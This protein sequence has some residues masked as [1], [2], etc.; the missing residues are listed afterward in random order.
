MRSYRAGLFSLSVAAL[1]MAGSSAEAQGKG[2]GKAKAKAGTAVKA[3]A[4]IDSRAGARLPDGTTV[5]DV[6]RARR[7]QRDRGNVILRDRRD[8]D[9]GIW[10]DG[11]RDGRRD[12]ASRVYGNGTK[13][14]PGLAKKP[15]QMP[16]GQYKKYYTT[17]QGA[18]VLSDILRGRGYPVQ[19]ISPYGDGQAVFYRRP[20][21]TIAR[22]VVSQRSDRLGFSN[23]PSAVLA[24][25]M[26]RLY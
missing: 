19:R 17:K 11:R 13:V 15:G 21:G 2:Q 26:A 22:A 1:L 6:I 23:I 5:D 25:V 10:R 3:N 9:D 18:G 7:D 16:P 14:P 12:G 24:E 4:A 20:D 8:R